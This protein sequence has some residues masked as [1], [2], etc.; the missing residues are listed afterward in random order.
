MLDDRWSVAMHWYE[1]EQQRQEWSWISRLIR[2]AFELAELEALIWRK[3]LR[4]WTERQTAV[5]VV[6]D[7]GWGECSRLFCADTI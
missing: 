7:W 3:I 2:D 1:R 4:C 6:A 5:W